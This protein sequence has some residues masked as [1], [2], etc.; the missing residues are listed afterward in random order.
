MKKWNLIIGTLLLCANFALGQSYNTGVGLRMGTE[1]GLTMRQRFY[2]NYAAEMLLQ[3]SLQ[4]EETQLTILGLIHKPI[5]TRRLNFYYGAGFHKGW[6]DQLEVSY[7]D[8]WGLD[9]IAGVELTIGR[10]NFS[11]DYKPAI[12]LSGGEKTFYSQTGVSLRYVIWKRD[13]YPWEQNSKK[14]RNKDKGGLFGIFK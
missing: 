10:I 8:P 3:S 11:Y 14:K 4:R 5:L 9:F 6:A 7:E 2:K 12:N 13:K 1:W